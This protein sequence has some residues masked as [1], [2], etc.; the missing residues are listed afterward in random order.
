MRFLL[1]A[2]LL[3]LVLLPTLG[4]GE[5]KTPEQQIVEDA[6]LTDADALRK[7]AEVKFKGLQ[8]VELENSEK[9]HIALLKIRPD[10]DAMMSAMPG[11]SAAENTEQFNT[12]AVCLSLKGFIAHGLKRDL[13]GVRT[14]ILTPAKTENGELTDVEILRFSLLGDQMIDFHNAADAFELV[15][16]KGLAIIKQTGTV[17]FEGFDQLDYAPAE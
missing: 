16:G 4:C 8:S 15:K 1:F 5:S 12:A 3:F 7:L 9:G 17:E 10:E 2:H 6:S 14:S 11:Q 13:H